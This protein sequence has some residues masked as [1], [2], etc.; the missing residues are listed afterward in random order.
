MTVM[1]QGGTGNLILYNKVAALP[2]KWYSTYYYLKRPWISY[3]YTL[4]T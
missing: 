3:K 4:Q 2:L 1:L